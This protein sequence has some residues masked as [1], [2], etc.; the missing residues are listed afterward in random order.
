MPSREGSSAGPEKRSKVKGIDGAK[1][2]NALL[3]ELKRTVHPKG[4]RWH[5]KSFCNC[6]R[7]HFEKI[8]EGPEKWAEI[9]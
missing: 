3:L 5:L 8:G 2:E 4:V 9:F 1:G 7:F 6:P